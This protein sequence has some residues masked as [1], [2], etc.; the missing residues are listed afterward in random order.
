MQQQPGQMICSFLPLMTNHLFAHAGKPMNSDLWTPQSFKPSSELSLSSARVADG[1]RRAHSM[2]CGSYQNGSHTTPAIYWVF[3]SQ[4]NNTN[5]CTYRG[6]SQANRI[7]YRTSRLWHARYTNRIRNVESCQA[8]FDSSLIAAMHE[9]G[10]DPNDMLR[11][12]SLDVLFLL[13]FGLSILTDKNG[14]RFV[15]GTWFLFLLYLSPLTHSQLPH[16]CCH[17]AHYQMSK[18]R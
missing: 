12:I 18:E 2:A 17:R 15:H 14:A 16:A 10:A 9:S 3:S 5:M 7:E 13:D 11:T 8:R 4:P 6:D 1:A